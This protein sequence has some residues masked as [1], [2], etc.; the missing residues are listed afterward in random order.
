MQN[1]IND[2]KKANLLQF[3]QIFSKFV[4]HSCGINRVSSCEHCKLRHV[5][6]E[7][8]FTEKKIKECLEEYSIF[9]DF[10]YQFYDNTLPINLKS[11]FLKFKYAVSAFSTTFYCWMNDV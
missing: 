7:V 9:I 5:F 11:T 1:E 8:K 2:L 3:L 6:V 10:L 4:E